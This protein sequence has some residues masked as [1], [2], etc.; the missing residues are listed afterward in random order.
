MAERGRHLHRARRR[1]RGGSTATPLVAI[2]AAVCVSVHCTPLVPATE[3]P[4]VSSREH[5][6]VCTGRQRRGTGTSLEVWSGG[7]AFLR[8]FEEPV[9]AT[10]ACDSPPMVA[11]VLQ[12]GAR[13]FEVHILRIAEGLPTARSWRL[14][15]SVIKADRISLSGDGRMLAIYQWKAGDD[16]GRCVDIWEVHTARLI[17]RCAMARPPA[18]YRLPGVTEWVSS[19]S[20]SPEGALVAASGGWAAKFT[21]G[22]PPAHW[23]QVWRVEDG[24]AVST[25]KTPFH[26]I[27][28]VSSET[29]YVAVATGAQAIVYELS[30]G[31]QARHLQLSADIESMWF[32]GLELHC[33]KEDATVVRTRLQ[34]PP[35]DE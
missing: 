5:L 22:P 33:R 19:L 8:F 25:F 34:G 21:G 30:S 35:S 1:G 26:G 17:S 14:E 9:T 4:A 12:K 32:E 31:H 29:R 10:G 7:K 6:R 20:F 27:V 11:V 23:V 24:A 2:V 3:E 15:G 28:A 18:E 13:R 16:G